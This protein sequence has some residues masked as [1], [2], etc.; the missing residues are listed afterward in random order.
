MIY[1]GCII[2]YKIRKLYYTY[3]YTNVLKSQADNHLE[4]PKVKSAPHRV[5]TRRA[6]ASREM[7]DAIA[8]M[9]PHGGNNLS[10]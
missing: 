2:I 10:A 5:V 6:M 3:S 1:N 9:I 4:I 7:H 8:L